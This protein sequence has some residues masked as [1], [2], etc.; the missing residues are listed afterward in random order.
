MADDECRTR[1]YSHRLA[2]SIG[3]EVRGVGIEGRGRF[4]EQQKR[5]AKGNGSG[6]QNALALAAREFGCLK[7]EY[8]G[9]EAKGRED[10]FDTTADI[11]V[12]AQ[13]VCQ[14]YEVASGGGNRLQFLWQIGSMLTWRSS[15]LM[16]QTS[17]SPAVRGTKPR[18]AR[19]SD[20][21]PDPLSPAMPDICPAVRLRLT[22]LKSVRDPKARVAERTERM[23]PDIRRTLGGFYKLVLICSG[24]FQADLTSSPSKRSA[25]PGACD[26]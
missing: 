26:A 20:V 21:L 1:P 7:V 8:F 22:L 17:T 14:G 15:S 6:E 18:M 4:V 25:P 12:G 10:G 16:P 5:L 23:E 3:D 9:I 19:S 2:Y 11:A 13:V 24:Y